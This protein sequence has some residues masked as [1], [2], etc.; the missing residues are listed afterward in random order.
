VSARFFCR[1]NIRKELSL[2]QQNN[3]NVN[4][5]NKFVISGIG[6]LLWDIFKDE[7]K[8]GGAPANFAYHVSALGHSGII[9]SRI[10]N[11][12]TGREAVDFLKELNLNT[13]YIQVDDKKPTG[14]V[15]VEMDEN[16]QPDYIIKE[17]VAWDF[18]E[19]NEKFN[20]LLSSA[21]AICFGTLAQR[22][23]ITRQTIL[24]FLE[25]AGNK[26]VKILDINLR[27][28]F[29][30]EQIIRE[31]LRLA[32]ILKLNTGELEV[33]SSL[34]QVNQKYN[35]KDLC[36]FFIDK[37]R[38]SLICLTKGEEGS[39]II[40]ASSYNESP[41]FPYGVVDRVG[42]GDSFT[43]AMII[44][45]LKGSTLSDI[46]EYA[47]KLASWVTSKKGGAPVYDSEI[48]KIMNI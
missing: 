5:K 7:K 35:E 36:R 19:W 23:E 4:M 11:D 25:T 32:D 38:L 18:L 43:A 37:Y 14:T 34:H 47:N 26:A 6:E 15:V 30:S 41:A 10:G 40:N 13:G 39:L 2:N 8:L 27:Q 21:D 1:Y 33:L 17:D 48:K 16:N 31:S 45:Y 44:L 29:Y 42:A 22:N 3:I 28:S 12:K 9:I 24:K 20:D 46:S